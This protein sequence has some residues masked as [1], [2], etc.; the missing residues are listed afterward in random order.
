MI[1]WSFGQEQ[2]NKQN[3][4]KEP[5]KGQYYSGSHTF[6]FLCS[7]HALYVSFVFM[8]FHALLNCLSTT[9]LIF[10][11]FCHWFTLQIFPLTLWTSLTLPSPIY[12]QLTGA[13]PEEKLQQ[14][15]KS[16]I[17]FEWLQQLVKMAPKVSLHW[18][19]TTI[20]QSS[21][22]RIKHQSWLLQAAGY[23]LLN[24]IRSDGCTSFWTMYAW[25]IKS[26][27]SYNFVYFYY[28]YYFFFFVW[29]CVVGSLGS[30]A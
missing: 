4:G 6:M 8:S 13:T 19:A 26:T 7:L 9:V 24:A 23:W 10:T 3:N 29:L 28:Y 15:A 25:T 16:F 17:K 1:P 2:A 12:P 18:T 14:K 20:H 21:R 22:Q 5:I 30:C 11:L 27:S